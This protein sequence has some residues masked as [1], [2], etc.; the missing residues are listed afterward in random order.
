MKQV[1]RSLPCSRMEIWIYIRLHTLVVSPLPP[2]GSSTCI[3]IFEQRSRKQHLEI[4]PSCSLN[5]CFRTGVSGWG[6]VRGE[7]FICWIPV[8]SRGAAVLASRCL[9]GCLRAQ[10]ATL[11]WPPTWGHHCHAVSWAPGTLALGILPVL[12]RKYQGLMCPRASQSHC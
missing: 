11:G 3:W 7:R 4:N 8:S 9:T 5:I 10:E 2:P 1:L 6:K 12:Q